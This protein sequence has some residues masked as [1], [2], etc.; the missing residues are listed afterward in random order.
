MPRVAN[1]ASRIRADSDWSKELLQLEVPKSI[2]A[3]IDEHIKGNGGIASRELSRLL[4]V[5]PDVLRK[6]LRRQDSPDDTGTRISG[7]VAYSALE[8]YLPRVL[9]WKTVAD[10][11][12]ELG[13]H[14]NTVESVVTQAGEQHALRYCQ[15]QKIYI[16]PTAEQF[17]RERREALKGI[18]SHELLTDFAKRMRVGLNRVTAFFSARKINLNNDIRGWA[19]VSPENKK[20]FLTW[21]EGVLERRRHNDRVIDGVVHR[22]IVRLAEEKADLLAQPGTARHRK[23][24]QREMGSFRDAARL[25]GFGK[26]TENGTYIPEDKVPSIF[27]YL[28]I[29]QAAQV[30]GVSTRT[31]ATWAKQYPDIVITGQTARRRWGVSLERVVPLAYKKYSEV[32]PL[33]EREH[34]PSLV[35]CFGI[36]RKA[37]SIGTTIKQLL[38]ALPISAKSEQ[39]LRTREGAIDPKDIVTLRELLAPQEDKLLHA[40]VPTAAIYS[41]AQVAQLVRTAAG[42]FNSGTPQDIYG[43]LFKNFRPGGTA[44]ASYDA[45]LKESDDKPVFPVSW[46]V[47]LRWLADPNQGIFVSGITK[48]AALV[49]DIYVNPDMGDFGPIVSLSS[50]EGGVLARVD[51]FCRKETLNFR[52]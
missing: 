33:S 35:M 4:H 25:R 22:S 52:V 28:S 38:A 18:E 29:G 11:A 5:R 17:V 13:V 8:G 45:L 7:P 6:Q 27:S 46:G 37:N 51:L 43:Y 50:D 36:D 1:L 9:G 12:D 42:R 2:R 26:K 34:V 23:I 10:F 21:R 14:R 24:M 15:D 39:S 19:R 30:C 3:E 31:I 48:R 40:L 41:C 44:P 47:L 32:K 49:G 20:I 16:S